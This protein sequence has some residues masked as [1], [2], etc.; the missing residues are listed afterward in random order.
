MLRC[1]WCVI[2]VIVR[3]LEAELEDWAPSRAPL[4]PTL[5]PAEARCLP[6]RPALLW[7]QILS[8]MAPR[9]ALLRDKGVRARP[10]VLERRR[11]GFGLVWSSLVCGE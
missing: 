9:P 5:P 4:F 3:S 11:V 10:A 1:G 7:A 6:R 8:L 2:V